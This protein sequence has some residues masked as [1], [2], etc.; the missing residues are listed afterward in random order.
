MM[1][2]VPLLAGQ[3]IVSVSSIILNLG[4]SLLALV[5]I[6]AAAWFFIPKLLK[7]IVR[8]RSPEVFLLTVVL[9]CL[10]LSWVTSHFG[11][12]LALGG[13]YRGC[14]AGRHGLQPSGHG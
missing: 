3:D 13:L 1:L 7:Q 5:V 9:M 4:G 8:L 2:M 6:V 14:R 12:S 10:G 11:L